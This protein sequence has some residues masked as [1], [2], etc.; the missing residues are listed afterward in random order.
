MVMT[1]AQN[2]ITSRCVHELWILKDYAICLGVGFL[3]FP[4][5]LK[6]VFSG[7]EEMVE[8]LYPKE[9]KE[10]KPLKA[11][12]IYVGQDSRIHPADLSGGPVVSCSI[13]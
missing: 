7:G 9:R 1:R 10:P 2:L 3:L 8:I 13:V 12:T 6:T 5:F 11:R 4:S